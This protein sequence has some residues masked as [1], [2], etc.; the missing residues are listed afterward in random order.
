MNLPHLT[1]QDHISTF[2]LFNNMTFI[3][4]SQISVK[5]ANIGEFQFKLSEEPFIGAYIE[6]SKGKRYAGTN[7]FQIGK[8]ITPVPNLP[9]LKEQG[10]NIDIQKFNIMKK[11]I[12][13]FLSNTKPIPSMKK[14]PSESDYIKGFFTR[15]FLRRINGRGYQEIDKEVYNSIKG[16][17]KT[18][19]HN[20]YEIGSIKWNLKGN[21]FKLNAL[22]LKKLERKWKSISYLFPIFDEF[23]RDAFKNQEGLYT[24]GGELYYGDSTE[25]IGDYH[26][27]TTKGP[28]KG[29]YHTETDHPKLYYTNELP[30]PPNMSYEEFMEGYPP[31]IPIIPPRNPD[32]RDNSQTLSPLLPPILSGASFNCVVAYGLPP[33]GYQGLMLPDGLVPVS[34]ACVDPGDGTGFYNKEDYGSRFQQACTTKCMGSTIPID[35]GYGVGCKIPWDPNFCESCSDHDDYFCAG[36]YTTTGGFSGGG[37]GGGYGGGG[38]GGQSGNC[39]IGETSIIMGDGTIKRIDKIIIG[40]I[41]KSEINTSEVKDIDTHKGIHTVYSINNT[42]AFVTEEHPFKTTTGWKAINPLETFKKHGIES[43]VLEIGDI[44]I[45]KKGTEELKSISKSS[46]TVNTVYNL[47]LN[48]EHVY[49]ANGYLVHNNKI[50]GAWGLGD[51]EEMQNDFG[52]LATE[53]CICG[54]FNG[55]VL[56]SPDCC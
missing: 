14:Y 16:K 32:E 11:G 34:S 18:Y 3:P 8:E 40:D 51:L 35:T 1:L 7:N 23:A 4:K 47:R 15:Y 21:I 48:N 24:E 12:K 30:T 25:Y 22:A 2:N 55:I 37:G 52:G 44:L 5:L 28:M 36:T 50:G 9:T 42:N 6:T 17:D 43:N 10:N 41:V 46:T 20:L 39:F 45:T 29:A 33:Q 31:K 27:H 13:D 56:Y 19:D 53:S 38:G 49:Y 54:M 26:V